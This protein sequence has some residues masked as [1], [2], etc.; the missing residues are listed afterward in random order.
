MITC[1]S[2]FMGGRRG[3]HRDRAQCCRRCRPRVAINP[4]RMTAPLRINDLSENDR[5]RLETRR[6]YERGKVPSS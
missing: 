6:P 3:A 2:L 1:V 5:V 4:D